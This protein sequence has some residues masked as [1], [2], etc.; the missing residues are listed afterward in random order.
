[1]IMNTPKATEHVITPDREHYSHDKAESGEAIET[2][3]HASNVAR[4]VP[5]F[6]VVPLANIHVGPG[7]LKLELFARSRHDGWA[8]WDNEMGEPHD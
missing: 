8:A 6:G 2:P 4:S 1:M 3:L 7:L 5:Q